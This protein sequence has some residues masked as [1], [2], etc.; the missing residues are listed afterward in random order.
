[1]TAFLRLTEKIAADRRVTALLLAAVVLV[2]FMGALGNGF[3]GDDTDYFLNNSYLRT[4]GK[5]LQIFV[6]GDS[7][8]TEMGDPYYRPVTTASIYYTAQMF[9]TE[10]FIHHLVSVLL[11]LGATIVF[12]LLLT[13]LASPG[14]ALA[15]A[16][17]YAVHPAHAEPVSYI[18]ARADLLC[19]LFTAAA[20]IFYLRRRES[21]KPSDLYMS[22]ALMTLGSFSKEPA[23]MLPAL[24]LV[25]ILARGEIK[26]EWRLPLFYLL[27]AFFYA[28][29]KFSI[30]GNPVWES[31][32]LT[33]RLATAGI[34]MA[35]TIA[36]S[37][38]P[39]EQTVMYPGGLRESFADPDVYTGWAIT[40]GFCAVAFASARKSS[41]IATGMGWFMITLFPASGIMARLVPSSV[42]DRYMYLPLM[43][44]VIAGA[45]LYELL[46]SDGGVRD[47]RRG[48]AVACALAVLVFGFA[49][50]LRTLTWKSDYTYLGKA[51]KNAPSH[52]RIA[53]LYA[54]ACMDEGKAQE[55]DLYFKIGDALHGMDP[56][57]L[58]DYALHNARLGNYKVALELGRK[59]ETAFP[60]HWQPPY[61]IGQI[62]LLM[63]ERGEALEWF[64]KSSELNPNIWPAR[65]MIRELESSIV[66]GKS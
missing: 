14:V 19:A 22:M 12:F 55:A 64:K 56:L 42:A 31:V 7:H 47:K 23:L 61:N 52:Q 34:N 50:G 60:D 10:P 16:L 28:A 51:F 46:A 27:P 15:G 30:M 21:G 49:T 18:S 57:T 40:V 48:L 63:D 37:L 54:K 53:G 66:A 36:W 58:S 20:F 2:V 62:Y 65:K 1:M 59:A 8:G 3:V 13:K 11:H 35:Q 26:K 25:H 29:V 44:L 5:F 41:L 24:I 9:G 45:G 17:I 39:I 4:P 38:L 32:P 6:N 33:H 43:G